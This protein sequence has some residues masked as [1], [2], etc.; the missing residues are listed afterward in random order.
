[1][2]QWLSTF[3]TLRPFNT[4]PYVVATPTIKLFPLTSTFALTMA[5][6][7]LFLLHTFYP[8][9]DQSVDE[10]ISRGGFRAYKARV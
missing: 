1:M 9:A 5:V 6:G 7:A 2:E 10:P 4:V 3:L 8:N